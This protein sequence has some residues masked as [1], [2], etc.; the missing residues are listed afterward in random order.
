[1]KG[2]P[3]N[4]GKAPPFVSK[5]RTKP[6]GTWMTRAKDQMA[7]DVIRFSRGRARILEIHDSDTKFG[8]GKGQVLARQ[9]FSFPNSKDF[10]N[11]LRLTI[12]SL[13][14]YFWLLGAEC[15]AQLSWARLLY[16]DCFVPAVPPRSF[17]FQTFS[18]STAASR[19]CPAWEK[20]FWK[21][22]LLNFSS[23]FFNGV[24]SFQWE[25]LS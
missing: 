19:S 18:C 25:K 15:R 11:I 5:G 13:P 8:K 7:K 17:V 14:S 23:S 24:P 4:L 3:F 1:M 21:R 16:G 2:I 10:S 9:P 6:R 22:C 12:P 20:T